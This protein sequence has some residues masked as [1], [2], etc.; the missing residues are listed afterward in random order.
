[1]NSYL[2][3]SCLSSIRFLDAGGAE[4]EAGC[5]EGAGAQ[6]ASSVAAARRAEGGGGRAL[7]CGGDGLIQREDGERRDADRQRRGER[8]QHHHPVRAEGGEAAGAH[9]THTHTCILKNSVTVIGMKNYCE[10]RGLIK[11]SAS[12]SA[13]VLG[14]HPGHAD[15]PRQHD[16]GPDPLYAPDVRGHGTRRHGDGR[17][18][19]GGLP[20]EEGQG[21]S[22]DGFCR[23]LQTP[24]IQLMR[25]RNQGKLSKCDAAF[26]CCGKNKKNTVLLSFWVKKTLGLPVSAISKLPSVLQTDPFLKIISDITRNTSK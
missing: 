7:L 11:H 17:Q 5:P 13:A 2:T 25:V 16:A 23:R 12:V 26:V 21:A 1:M 22:A 18:R 14:L 8:L 24:Q 4:R 19:A 3:G 10:P 15:Q 6:E 20:A 9:D